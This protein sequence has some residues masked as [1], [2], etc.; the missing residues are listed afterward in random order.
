VR[1]DVLRATLQWFF[2]RARDAIFNRSRAFCYRCEYCGRRTS[3][4][5]TRVG[6]RLYPSCCGPCAQ[7]DERWRPRDATPEELLTLIDFGPEIPASA[8]VPEPSADPARL[9]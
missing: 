8:Y 3:M 9:P 6:T 4:A 5:P 2:G 7:K 1:S